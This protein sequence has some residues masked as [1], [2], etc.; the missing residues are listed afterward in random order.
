PVQL[1]ASREVQNA[2]P[3]A[4]VVVLPA[5]GEVLQFGGN[6]G[7]VCLDQSEWGE[8]P[9]HR[10]ALATPDALAGCHIPDGGGLSWAEGEQGLPVGRESQL[11]QPCLPG[12]ELAQFPSAVRLPQADEPTPGGR[13]DLAIRGKRGLTTPGRV[14]PVLLLSSLGNPLV[15]WFGFAAL[16]R[17]TPGETADLLARGKVPQTDH[18]VP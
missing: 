9:G 12:L 2:D 4:A 17:L 14:V 5:K 18:L 13:H 16:L 3:M 11:Q 15:G 8:K 10:L 7:V 6:Q 1:L